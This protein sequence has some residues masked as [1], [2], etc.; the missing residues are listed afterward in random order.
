MALMGFLLAGSLLPSGCAT[1]LGTAA[2]PFTTPGSYWKH[3]EGMLWTKALMLPLT[4]PLGPFIG[5]VQ[6]VRCDAG[7]VMH[8]AYGEGENPDFE[9]I[10]DPTSPDY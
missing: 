1:V 4:I 5:F 6:G 10:W 3:T 2:G 7:F 9:L 8:G